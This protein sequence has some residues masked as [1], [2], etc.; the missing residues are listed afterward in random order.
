MT[1]R[2]LRNAAPNA[3]L[4]MLKLEEPEWHP[5]STS[6]TRLPAVSGVCSSKGAFLHALPHKMQAIRAAVTLANTTADAN[7]KTTVLCEGPD[8]ERYPL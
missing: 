6:S 5:L 1:L 4:L 2:H 3:T 7:S 8:G